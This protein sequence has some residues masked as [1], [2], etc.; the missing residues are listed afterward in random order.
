MSKWLLLLVIFAVGTQQTAAT[1]QEWIVVQ[2]DEARG[3]V[4][5]PIEPT[6]SERT[7]EPVANR[8]ITL[9]LQIALVD[10]K[11]T[12]MFGY[13]DQTPATNMVEIKNILDGGV[14]GAITR[15]FG[16]L[17]K[18]EE[19]K[20]DGLLGRQFQ[21]T[22]IQGENKL[23]VASRLILEGGRLY[24]LNY[25]SPQDAFNAADAKKFLESFESVK[26]VNN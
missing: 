15:T 4:R 5:M 11:F 1:A 6:A 26:P 7:I 24:Q 19:I 13:H 20:V 16:A 25:I 2:P 17:E 23:K 12:Y 8:P 9:K 21:Y 10:K 3:R 14:K 18:V 22:C